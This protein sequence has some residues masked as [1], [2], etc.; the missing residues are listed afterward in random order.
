VQASLA[1]EFGVGP[2]SIGVKQ[3]S[4]TDAALLSVAVYKPWTFAS[5][6]G[7]GL[8]VDISQNQ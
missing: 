6:G 8:S 3:D 1:G 2:I 5:S 7:S 4:L